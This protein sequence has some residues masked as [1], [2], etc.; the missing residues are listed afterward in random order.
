LR[1]LRVEADRRTAALIPALFHEMFGDPSRDHKLWPMVKIGDICEVKGGKR[2]PKGENYS[3]EPTPFR[4][5]RIRDI[6]EGRIDEG[7]L[8]FLKPETQRQISRYTVNTGD[9]IITIAGTIGVIAPVGETLS[10]ANL[11]ENAAK[12][13]P[14]H[15]DKYDTIFLSE[16]LQTS[17]VQ[18]QIGLRTGRVT[19]G[20]LALF[21]IEQISFP[22][23]PLPLQNEFAEQIVE[24]HELATEQA[25]S[26]Q[27]LNDLFQSM[28]H[29]AF[30]GGL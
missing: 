13:V 12:L 30:S 23:P 6:H 11:T 26:G 1:K 21:R 29:R 14:R 17:F 5:I 9:I 20:K 2:L 22:L 24:V 18:N 16:L 7:A 15:A 4:Y 27:R 10:G 8:C 25:A 19:I 3:E 28:L